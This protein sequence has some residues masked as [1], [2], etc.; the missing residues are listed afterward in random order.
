MSKADI[1]RFLNNRLHW[2]YL[3]RLIKNFSKSSWK[4]KS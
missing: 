3:S 4:I 1:N 2:S